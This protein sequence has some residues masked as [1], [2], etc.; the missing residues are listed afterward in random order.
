MTSALQSYLN[1]KVQLGDRVGQIVDFDGPTTSFFVRIGNETVKLPFADARL[2]LARG[3]P[4]SEGERFMPQ[5]T[6]LDILT[7]SFRASVAMDIERLLASGVSWTVA[8]AEVEAMVSRAVPA[9]VSL[10][11]PKLRALRNW[12]S[13]LR[14]DGPEA[15]IGKTKQRGNRTPRF[16]ELAEKTAEEVIG[17]SILD[18]A[19]VSIQS[20][21]AEFRK[22]YLDKC[23]SAGIEP[24]NCGAKV[25]NHVLRGI[26]LARLVQAQHGTK[27]K[28]REFLKALRL[29]IISSPLERVELDVFILDI[30][31]VNEEG[32][33]IGRPILCAAIDVA[34]GVILGF[35]LEIGSPKPGIVIE[36]IRRT[37]M[38]F[39]EQRFEKLR[40]ENRLQAF[41]RP[42][43]LVCDNGSENAGERL[44]RIVVG[45]N[46]E[47]HK[48]TPGAPQEKPF[49]ER[50]GGQV[51]AFVRTLPG[52]LVYRRGDKGDAIKAA[53][54]NAALSL[55]Q[56]ENHVTKWVY[57]VY[58]VSPRDRVASGLKKPK[59]PA[60]C[61][62]EL[63]TQCLLPPPPTPEEIRRLI[64]VE[65]EV[66]TLQLDGIQFET[67]KFHSARLK[68]L[69]EHIGTGKSVQ[70]FANLDDL[71]EIDVIDPLTN[72]RFTVPA[73]QK[74]VAPVSVEDIRAARND[75]SVREKEYSAQ[76]QNYRIA[77]EAHDAAKKSRSRFMRER[78]A[79]EQARREVEKKVSSSTEP[80]PPLDLGKLAEP[81]G[82]LD[83]EV[84]EELVPLKA[85][86]RSVEP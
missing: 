3:V 47:V 27:I 79:A 21:S 67:V 12:L 1:Q 37:L 17:E 25:F 7:G 54:E 22:R 32:E 80:R 34:T 57:D 72:E 13:R 59:A 65:R 36:T 64:M 66:R 50:F 16:D 11:V 40:I 18:G 71:R 43:R 9:H 84:P 85:T 42:A 38:P 8:R 77:M 68:S 15:L 74:F 78:R 73:K 14:R 2:A 86:L 51:Q 5:P 69:I 33:V 41:G 26:P 39:D 19:R 82:V 55:D 60:E 31:I 10:R 4:R 75:P 76:A 70:I 20:A 52:G 61:W 53:M 23:Q 6:D 24:G 83:V 28:N 58:H 35:T 44:E 46:L 81:P 45:L 56:L 62:T 49:I 63:Q 29:I 48:T 30:Y